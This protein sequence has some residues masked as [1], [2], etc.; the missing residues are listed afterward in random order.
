MVLRNIFGPRQEEVQEA[1]T[2]MHCSQDESDKD[3]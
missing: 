3:A 1:T 2:G